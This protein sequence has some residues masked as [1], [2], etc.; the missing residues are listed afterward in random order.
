M[1]TTPI[2]KADLTMLA[3]TAYKLILRKQEEAE[4]AAADRAPDLC[5]IPGGSG[6]RSASIRK[7]VKDASQ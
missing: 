5:L 2:V 7:Y 1:A 4:R 6:D 3:R